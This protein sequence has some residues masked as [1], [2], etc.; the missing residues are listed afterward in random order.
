[1]LG[2][3]QS[4]VIPDH[5]KCEMERKTHPRLLLDAADEAKPAAGCR[6]TLLSSER[7]NLAFVVLEGAE[8][9]ELLCIGSVV[10]SP[11]GILFHFP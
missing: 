2:S 6:R 1:M 8:L 4:V 5:P 7:N 9:Q 3:E 11:Q 10:G